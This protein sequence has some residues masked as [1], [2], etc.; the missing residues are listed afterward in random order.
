MEDSEN[1]EQRGTSSVFKERTD[2][3]DSAGRNRRPESSEV[4]AWE[5]E[6]SDAVAYLTSASAAM[7]RLVELS[8]Y[9]SGAVVPF[10]IALQ[11]IAV[12]LISLEEC[13]LAIWSRMKTSE[14]SRV[15]PRSC[16]VHSLRGH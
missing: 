6:M 4:M 5:T 3:T 10:D 9:G 14:P 2:F 15:K 8:P 13:S 12:A 7:Q 16:W 11:G 1:P